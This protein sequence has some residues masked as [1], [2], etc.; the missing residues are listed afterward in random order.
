[1]FYETNLDMNP[2]DFKPTYSA[3]QIDDEQL[4]PV[5]CVLIGVAVV[6]FTAVIVLAVVL[7]RR[8]G[9]C[10][11]CNKR[12][13]LDGEANLENNDISAVETKDLEA[14]PSCG[15]HQE[16]VKTA[17]TKK[18]C[19]EV[20]ITILDEES[21]EV[22]LEGII[23]VDE[24]TP[25]CD[26]PE[27]EVRSALLSVEEEIRITG[28]IQSLISVEATTVEFT[29][30]VQDENIDGEDQQST[31]QEELLNYCRSQH[32]IEECDVYENREEV[33][34]GSESE[35]DEDEKEHLGEKNIIILQQE[36]LGNKL[37]PE[38]K[39]P[40][41]ECKEDFDENR[42]EGKDNGDKADHEQDDDDEED[43][44][45]E[46]GNEEVEDQEKGEEGELNAEGE[47]NREEEDQKWEMNET[48]ANEKDQ[49][50]VLAV[51]FK[52]FLPFGHQGDGVSTI[53]QEPVGV[54]AS[55]NGIVAVADLA[56]D[57]IKVFS[58]RGK[59]VRELDHYEKQ[60]GKDV[61][62]LCPT[63]LAFD[64]SGNIVVVERGRHRVTVMTPDGKLLRGFGRRGK[65]NGQLWFPH[66]VSVDSHNRIIVTDTANS[67]VQVF[68]SEGMLLLVFGNN[69][70]CNLDY[71]C[72]ALYHKDFFYVSDTDN[73]CIKVFDSAGKFIRNFT[74]PGQFSAPS[75]IA[76]FRDK[77]LLVCDY[78]NDCV[79]VFTLDGEYVTKF[80]T[81]GKE[82]GQFSGP[83]AVAVLPSGEIVV[84]DKESGRVHVFTQN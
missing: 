6:I 1:M 5:Y 18:E 12:R 66:G 79:K 31:L 25:T 7:A 41:E 59:L 73:D 55:S 51:Q 3:L 56:N 69:C 75:G 2:Q 49:S 63:G 4:S 39:T 82:K 27:R 21:T 34:D 33:D 35:E 37:C 40:G 62:L 26:S 58:K 61:C 29:W 50:I 84:T 54:A 28:S 81:S 52:E 48:L 13:A 20:R 70:Q 9:C 74:G 78:N 80:G 57:L 16:C 45:K 68:D 46:E 32:E 11:C 43:D 77:Y 71:P 17:S 67:R 8:L 22:S 10:G 60:N 14:T 64:N 30:A 15:N 44:G 47:E 83:E 53:V 24:E 65:A 38:G 72:Y 76:V 19:A 36:E 42:D 23:G